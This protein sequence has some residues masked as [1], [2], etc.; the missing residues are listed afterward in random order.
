MGALPAASARC[1]QEAPPWDGVSELTKEQLQ[2][3]AGPPP[4]R[5]SEAVEDYQRWEGFADMIPMTSLLMIA[6]RPLPPHC[7]PRTNSFADPVRV[8]GCPVC[9]EC[10]GP[11]LAS[12]R[13]PDRLAPDIFP[14]CQGYL[15]KEDREE[16]QAYQAWMALGYVE[17]LRNAPP[18]VQTRW[19]NCTSPRLPGLT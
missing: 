16:E 4:I 11:W 9:Q 8:G 15:C 5:P 12:R 19:A 6:E 17:H 3:V 14:H 2:S 18:E 1:V 10:L 7:N 13:G